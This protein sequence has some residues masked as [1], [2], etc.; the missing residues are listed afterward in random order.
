MPV[1]DI[2]DSI[3]QYRFE[4]TYGRT[5]PIEYIRPN[6]YCIA[7]EKTENK[8]QVESY[9]ISDAGVI[10]TPAEHTLEIPTASF[11]VNQTCRR[12][13]QNIV[14]LNSGA[15]EDMYLEAVKVADDGTL[16]QDATNDCH[17]DPFK[18]LWFNTVYQ[19]GSIITNFIRHNNE[20][21]HVITVEVTEAGAVTC[22]LE[23][24]FNVEDI[25]SSR[26]QGIRISD[27]VAL[28]AYDRNSVDIYARPVGV[29]ADGTVSGLAQA[30]KQIS[31]VAGV[32]SR[33]IHLTA[34]WYVLS[35][36]GP[37]SFLN[38]CVFQCA[39]AGTITVPANNTYQVYNDRGKQPQITKLTDNMI[40]IFSTDSDYKG[41][42]HT[43]Q[44]TLTDPVVW[45]V[46]DSKSIAAGI[47]NPWGSLLVASGVLVLSY[48]DANEHGWLWT[49]EV[50]SEEAV[51][52]D[53]SL[54][55]GIGP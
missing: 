45:S 16:S 26:V 28:I 54:M 48:S 33:L 38:L 32:P 22:P 19:R 13:D 47:S 8:A 55:M 10:T 35:I 46:H 7:Y 11:S 9:F 50:Q 3:Q 29:A 20:V 6:L 24:W 21:P 27:G 31:N 12:P 53:H 37:G 52:P 36:Q 2:G 43:V 18:S 40:S 30:T 17:L 4:D 1:G 15:G 23:H 25:V 42:L 51:A 5:P 34:D 14:I 41:W 44:I 39:A 49:Y